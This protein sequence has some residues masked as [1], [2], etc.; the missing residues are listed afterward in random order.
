MSMANTCPCAR[1]RTTA[2]PRYRVSVARVPAIDDLRARNARSTA[3]STEAS[4]SDP[5][6][7]QTRVYSA[8]TR[9]K[10]GCRSPRLMGPGGRER[11]GRVRGEAEAAEACGSPRA[12]AS[13]KR[14]PACRGYDAVLPHGPARFAAGSGGCFQTRSV[15]AAYFRRPGF[16]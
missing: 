5:E 9:H 14:H 1:R 7:A 10:R 16:P 6:W 8:A 4:V 15:E 11:S 13:L 2:S 12:S 3:R